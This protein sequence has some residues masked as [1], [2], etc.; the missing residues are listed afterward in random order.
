MVKHT[1]TIMRIFPIYESCV[2]YNTDLDHSPRLS[3]YICMSVGDVHIVITL[4]K[5]MPINVRWF[6]D[7]NE[8]NRF[9]N[10]IKKSY[11]HYEEHKE[12][13]QYTN[14]PDPREDIPF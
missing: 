3:K 11:K 2:L 5:E 7:T 9:I 8:Y 4:F 6:T 13:Y 10:T 1:I 12:Q 14:Y